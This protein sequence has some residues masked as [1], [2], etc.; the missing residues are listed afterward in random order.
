MDAHK[1]IHFESFIVDYLADHGW[2]VGEAAHYDRIR[3]LYPGDQIGYIQ[4]TQPDAWEKLDRL[5]GA[6][7]AKLILDRVV[8]SAPWRSCAAV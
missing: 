3:A 1:E 2:L 6:A 5:N 4:D 7:T 8:A